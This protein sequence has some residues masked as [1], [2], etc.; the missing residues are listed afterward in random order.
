MQ[1][2]KATSEPGA[3]VRPPK[4]ARDGAVKGHDTVMLDFPKVCSRLWH[5]V[6]GVRLS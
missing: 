1:Q 3:P 2:A 4:E 6:L 5:A